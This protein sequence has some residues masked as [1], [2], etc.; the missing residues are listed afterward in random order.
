MS[1]KLPPPIIS[2]NP[3]EKVPERLSDTDRMKEPRKI[4]PSTET[5]MNSQ[6]LG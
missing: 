3:V 1:L 2:G 4:G 5:Y 6:I